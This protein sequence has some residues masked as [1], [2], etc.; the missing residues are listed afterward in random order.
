MNRASSLTLGHIGAE[1][2][3][4]AVNVADAIEDAHQLMTVPAVL[5][6]LLVLATG[7]AVVVL[8]VLAVTFF[9]ALGGI[10]YLLYRAL[11]YVCDWAPQPK[12]AR[13]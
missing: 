12:G 7:A 3:T 6:A 9:A 11:A 13:T 8:A 5:L 2:R 10:G 4:V 1:I